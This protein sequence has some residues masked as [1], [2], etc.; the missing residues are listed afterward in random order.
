LKRRAAGDRQLPVLG[1]DDRKRLRSIGVQLNGVAVDA[2][3]ARLRVVARRR[4]HR[5]AEEKE[6]LIAGVPSFGEVMGG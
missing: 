2:K 1:V 4:Q 3:Q 5:V 6:E